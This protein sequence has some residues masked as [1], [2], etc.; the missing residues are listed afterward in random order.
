MAVGMVGLCTPLGLVLAQCCSLH[1]SSMQI[2]RGT[3]AKCEVL[4][5][6]QDIAKALPETGPIDLYTSILMVM[7]YCTPTTQV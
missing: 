3:G 7:L 4:G 2:T 1:P 5:S 6:K